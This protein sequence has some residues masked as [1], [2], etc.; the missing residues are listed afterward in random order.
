MILR[1][2]SSR[3]VQL[4]QMFLLEESVSMKVFREKTK[5]INM[6]EVFGLIQ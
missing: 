4:E 3:L 1:L 6:I 2:K 5:N